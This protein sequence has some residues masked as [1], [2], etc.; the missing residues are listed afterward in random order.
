MDFAKG[1][2]KDYQALQQLVA[3]INVTVLGMC[4]LS[5]VV[6]QW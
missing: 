4:S 1:D 6:L 3:P 2:D 5:H